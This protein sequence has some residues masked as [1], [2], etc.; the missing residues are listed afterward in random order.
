MVYAFSYA[1]LLI[2]VVKYTPQALLNFRRKSTIGWSIHNILLDA[3]G[4]ILSLAQLFIDSSLNHDWSGVTGNPIKFGLGS[5]SLVYDALFCVQHFVL[6]RDASEVYEAVPVESDGD[7]ESTLAGSGESE[8]S[9]PTR[10]G[11]IGGARKGSR[12]GKE[13]AIDEGI[14]GVDIERGVD[15]RL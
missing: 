13:V 15:A 2:S 8:G 5:I 9:S 6:Y 12:K 1:K 11:A 7:E 3:S 4:G 14:E 10:Y